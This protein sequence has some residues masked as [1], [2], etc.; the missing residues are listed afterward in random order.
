MKVYRFAVV[1]RVAAGTAH[2][3]ECHH[4]DE[5]RKQI[6]FACESPLVGRGSMT[7]LDQTLGGLAITISDGRPMKQI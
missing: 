7:P 5:G 6:V 4:T 1:E 2:E 3:E